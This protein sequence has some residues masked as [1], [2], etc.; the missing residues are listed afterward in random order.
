MKSVYLL[1]GLLVTLCAVT[2]A[3]TMGTVSVDVTSLGKPI[4]QDFEGFSIQFDPSPENLFRGVQDSPGYVLGTAEAP[5]QV[6]YQLIK[7]L[8]AGTLRTNSGEVSEPCWDSSSAPFPQACPWPITHDIVA[9]YAKASAATGWGVIVEVNL[10]QN[11][12]A[13]ALEFGRAY[14]RAFRSAPGS[15][16]NGFEIGNEPDLYEGEILFGR[17]RVR[18][19]GYSWRDLASEWK[20]YIAA[21]HADQETAK[22]PLI[23]PAFDSGGWT[24][25]DLGPFLDAVG[26]KNLGFATVH[27]YATN[28]CNG[29][30][31]TLDELL[32][33]A[34]ASAYLSEA[35]QWVQATEARG[36]HLVLGETNSVACEGQKGLSDTFVSALW[37]LDWLFTNASAGMRGVYVH[38][39]NSY[40]SPVFVTTYANPDDGAVQYVDTV[41]P[42]YY[43]MYAFSK[44]AE[45]KHLLP[46]DT[47]SKANLAAYAV[48]GGEGDAVTVFIINRDPQ[49]GGTL[50]IA[51]SKSMAQAHLLT[52]A[53]PSLASEDISW[54]GV[55][56]DNRTGLLP[57]EGGRTLVQPNA[58]GAYEVPISTASIAILTIEP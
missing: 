34:K 16:I 42:L 29:R 53:A 17:R 44:F 40:Y 43:A 12:P 7:N 49:L 39:N 38:M 6:M 36:L 41:A 51:L 1:C 26:P 50:T 11:D 10:A 52:I 22:I 47:V 33:P 58:S 18:P 25:P 13:W 20:P 24:G 9:G 30:V 37:G 28:D 57:R 2:S 3:Q 19:A 5:N 4:P 23:G 55:K 32:S 35:T 15:R 27:D 56:F 14:V 31:A 21:F 48:R 45:G 46:A 8:G 54:G